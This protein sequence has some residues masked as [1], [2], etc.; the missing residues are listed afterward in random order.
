MQ[1]TK[2]FNDQPVYFKIDAPLV[3]YAK[4]L[5]YFPAFHK[6]RR[7]GEKSYAMQ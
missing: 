1:L 4:D 5:H 7:Q 2:K 6:Y 3:N